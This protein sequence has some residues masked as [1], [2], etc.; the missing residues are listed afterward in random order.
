MT[1]TEV[2]NRPKP[3]KVVFLTGADTESTRLCIE[4]V[5]RVEGVLVAGVLV[6]V[7]NLRM[8]W[9][10]DAV[11]QENASFQVDRGDLFIILGG[12]G[13]GESTL[14]RHLVGLEEPLGSER[15]PQ[16]DGRGEDC[17]DEGEESDFEKHFEM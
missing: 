3:F 15:F 4:S 8:G 7:T 1:V 11:L 9:S 12:S 13:C 14:L 2:N 10:A 6:D 5:C 17:S 16:A